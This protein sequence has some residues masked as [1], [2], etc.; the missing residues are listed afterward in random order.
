MRNAVQNPDIAPQFCRSWK[1]NQVLNEKEERIERKKD[2]S[3]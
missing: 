1:K 3:L 2:I